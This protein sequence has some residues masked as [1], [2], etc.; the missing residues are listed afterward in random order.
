MGHWPANACQLTVNAKTIA[1]HA[2][3][4]SAGARDND[5]TVTVDGCGNY[6]VQLSFDDGHQT[7]LYSWDTLYDL[8]KHQAEHWERYLA[9][10]EAAGASR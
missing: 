4:L 6:A 8:G 5:I 3:Y 2:V 1:R 9:E 7:G 10:L